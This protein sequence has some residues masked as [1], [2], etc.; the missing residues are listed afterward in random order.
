MDARSGEWGVSGILDSRYLNEDAGFVDGGPRLNVCTLV[1]AVIAALG[2]CST[3][4]CSAVKR[5]EVRIRCESME[6][7]L[8]TCLL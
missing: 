1:S 7:E 2:V 3:F 5:R 8:N 6:I 4:M